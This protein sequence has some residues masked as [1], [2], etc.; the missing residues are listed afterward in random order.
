MLARE[1]VSGIVK[2]VLG[3]RFRNRR[4]ERLAIVLGFFQTRNED[5]SKALLDFIDQTNMPHHSNRDIVFKL[6]CISSQ[7]SEV[8]CAMVKCKVHV[9]NVPFCFGRISVQISRDPLKLE[10]DGLR[11]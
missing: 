2:I 3:R 6:D 10:C 9:W 5:T 11:I 1:V 4:D 8:I 7:P